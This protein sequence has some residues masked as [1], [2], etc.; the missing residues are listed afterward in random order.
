MSDGP[1]SGSLTVMDGGGAA[2]V[3]ATAQLEN[4]GELEVGS[5]V[6][7]VYAVSVTTTTLVL[8]ARR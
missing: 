4:S 8:T 1:F 5:T 2:E 3:V 7:V 6:S